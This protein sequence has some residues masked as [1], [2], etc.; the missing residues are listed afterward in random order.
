VGKLLL[1]L[2]GLLAGLD[3]GQTTTDGAGLLGTEIQGGVLLGLVEQTKLVTLGLVD[4]SQN[5]SDCLAGSTTVNDKASVRDTV[6]QK[7]GLVKLK[8]VQI[9]KNGG[10]SLHLLES[11]SSSNLLDTK[12]GELL[13][14]LIKLLGELSLVLVAK[15][16]GFN[17]DLHAT[18]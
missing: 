14:K 5:T 9:R 6:I 18:K 13:L 4:N 2:D 3:L 1:L 11:S 15:F 8:K 16:V 7:H 17:G 10:G 12:G